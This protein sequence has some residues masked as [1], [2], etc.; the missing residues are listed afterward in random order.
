MRPCEICGN[1]LK[2]KQI[3]CCCAECRKIWEH[4]KALANPVPIRYCE[5]PDCGELLG[6]WHKR[7][8]S[9]KCREIM[10]GSKDRISAKKE[11]TIMYKV[12]V[13]CPADGEIYERL[14]PY[15]PTIMP[16]LYCDNHDYYRYISEWGYYGKELS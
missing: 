11:E 9:V 6:K 16:R 4:R 15:K 14:L 10:A 13:K 2:K 7:F 12:L 3:H 1:P 5:N 8:C